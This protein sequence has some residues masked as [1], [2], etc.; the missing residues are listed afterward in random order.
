MMNPGYLVKSFYG[1]VV[2]A[3]NAE[4]RAVSAGIQSFG[5]NYRTIQPMLGNFDYKGA[6][7]TLKETNLYQRTSVLTQNTLERLIDSKTQIREK[8]QNLRERIF[9]PQQ[10]FVFNT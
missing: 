5:A 3:L 2:A 1:E 6:I 8:A 10:D 9:I 4:Y 7:D